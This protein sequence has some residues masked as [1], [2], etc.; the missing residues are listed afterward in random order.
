M[1]NVF[2]V[3]VLA[4]ILIACNADGGSPRCIHDDQV[5]GLQAV[6]VARTD[7]HVGEYLTGIHK[8]D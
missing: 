7:M 8:Y 6:D 5:G 1:R 2:L 3:I 4:F